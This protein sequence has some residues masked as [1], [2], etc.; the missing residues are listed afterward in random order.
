MERC[1]DEPTNRWQENGQEVLDQAQRWQGQPL[2]KG[3]LTLPR[4]TSWKE[5]KQEFKCSLGS[6]GPG[7]EDVLPWWAFIGWQ[8]A[9]K[10][11]EERGI[12]GNGAWESWMR[13]EMSGQLGHLGPKRWKRLLIRRKFARFSELSI[14]RPTWGLTTPRCLAGFNLALNVAGISPKLRPIEFPYS[15]LFYLIVKTWFGLQKINKILKFCCFMEAFWTLGSL[16]A[17]GWQVKRQQQQQF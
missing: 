5:R 1:Q 4:S 17:N 11:V 14:E 13:E 8:R 16:S 3:R 9:S 6:W 2:P 10:R 7:T 15:I 12:R